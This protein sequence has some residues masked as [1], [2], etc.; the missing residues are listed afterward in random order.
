MGTNRMTDQTRVTLKAKRSMFVASVFI[1]PGALFEVDEI[2]GA[3]L[4]DIRAAE[5]ATAEEAERGPVT[6]AP[7]SAYRRFFA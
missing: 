6:I 2:E 3:C 4:I 1:A 5:R 7:P